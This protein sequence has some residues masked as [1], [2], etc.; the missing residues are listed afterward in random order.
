MH[1]YLVV[2]ACLAAIALSISCS[3]DLSRSQALEHGR[4]S[5][6]HPATLL[7]TIGKIGDSCSRQP[8][9]EEILL[10]RVGVLTIRKAGQRQWEISLTPF[11]QKMAEKP[12]EHQMKDGCDYWTVGIPVA[13]RQNL[14]ITGIRQEGNHAIADLAFSLRLTDLGNRFREENYRK[15][16]MSELEIIE[17][18]GTFAIHGLGHFPI[19]DQDLRQ[20]V[21]I[22][23]AKYDD[24][25]R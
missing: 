8:T 22:S 25:W 18:N 14:Q 6:D 9:A 3:G 23:F 19:A 17:L 1:R 12:V 15:L 10:T 16:E 21:E 11:G 20:T 7:P 4:W 5:Y 2:T 13:Q 24:G